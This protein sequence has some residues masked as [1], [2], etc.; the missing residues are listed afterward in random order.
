MTDNI[1]HKLLIII[2]SRFKKGEDK[3]TKRL[4]A[5][6]KNCKFNSKNTEKVPIKK[7]ILIFFSDTL[8]WIMGRKEEDNLGN[9]LACDS[10]SV[11][12]KTAESLW[13]DC[14]KGY[15]HNNKNK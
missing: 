11:Y 5:I 7:R 6:C 13:E 14:P 8:S 15:W 2:K 4:R 9:C 3:E 10:C 1:G 12:F